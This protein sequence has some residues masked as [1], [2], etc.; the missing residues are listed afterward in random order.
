MIPATA[1]ESAQDGRYWVGSYLT[2]SSAISL[3]DGAPREFWQLSQ[4]T[5]CN[6]RNNPLTCARQSAI[7]ETEQWRLRI[8]SIAIRHWC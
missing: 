2:A 3:A 5:T 6:S 1:P 8:W 4:S 7:T